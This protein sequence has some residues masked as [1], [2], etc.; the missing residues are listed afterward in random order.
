MDPRNYTFVQW[1]NIAILVLGSAASAAFWQDFMSASHSAAVSGG[2]V[3]VAG[4]L[5]ILVGGTKAVAPA[6][7][8]APTV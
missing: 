1:M 8:V 2:L 3:W 7:P 4:L 6:A 5:N